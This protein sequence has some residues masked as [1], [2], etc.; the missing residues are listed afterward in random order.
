V[1]YASR[2]APLLALV[3]FACAGCGAYADK[4]VK[5]PLILPGYQQAV[6]AALTTPQSAKPPLILPAYKPPP[7]TNMIGAS[8]AATD[9]LVQQLEP[10]FPPGTR[11]IVTTLVSIN[12]LDSSS[13]MGRLISEQM[14]N[15]FTHHDYNVIE[16]KTGNRLYVKRN[17]GELI[18]TREIREIAQRHN[19]QL[20]VTG[21]Y[22]ETPDRVFISLKVIE[23]DSDLV[24]AA[25]DFMLDNDKLVRS[26]LH[27]T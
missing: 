21:T 20:I 1:I 12:Q 5:P 25:F 11:I 6:V 16:A 18:L 10:A 22:T 2:R 13:P 15:R 4:I 27:P 24:K 23:W 9:T 17:E 19:V 8:Y 26:L 7:V 14:A 3:A